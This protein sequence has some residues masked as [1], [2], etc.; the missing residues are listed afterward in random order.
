MGA[1]ILSKH[2]VRHT[3]NNSLN[4]FNRMNATAISNISFV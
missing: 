4:S 2:F 1:K 3:F